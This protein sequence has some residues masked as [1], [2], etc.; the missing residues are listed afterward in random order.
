MIDQKILGA[1]F[2]AK[3]TPRNEANTIA[4]GAECRVAHVNASGV[5]IEVVGNNGRFP[6]PMLHVPLALFGANFTE[7]GAPNNRGYVVSKPFKELYR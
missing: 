6:K 5:S 3:N 2:I 7:D 4:P 1:K